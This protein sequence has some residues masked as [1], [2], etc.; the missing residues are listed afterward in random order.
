[1]AKITL[2]DLVNLQNETTAVNAINNNNAAIEVAMENTLSRDGT[3]PN[4]MGANLD[5]N[6]NR[7]LNLPSAASADEPV[8]LQDL[9][10]YA[11]GGV[12]TFN[13]VPVGGTTGQVLTKNSNTDYD[14]SWQ[15]IPTPPPSS[16]T[17]VNSQTGDVI[18]ATSPLGRLTLTS[19]TA[20]TTADVTG[21]T[22]IYYTFSQGN[23]IPIYSGT[24]MVPTTFTELTLALDSNGS[25]TN[26]HAANKNFDLFVFNNAGTIRL[27]TGPDWTAGAVAGSDTAR[28]TGLGSTELQLINGLFTNK[29][30]TLIRW[31]SGS[32]DT[33]TV[34]ANQATYVGTLRTTAN[35]Q[36][37]DSTVNRFVFN[38]Y[39]QS[40]RTF[41]R[42]ELTASWNYST[43][44]YRQANANAANKVQYVAGLTGG[45]I[46]L[47]VSSIP[48]NSTTTARI[49][50]TGVGV[51][52]TAVNS[53][54]T[55]DFARVGDATVPS[56]VSKAYFTGYASLGYH[57]MAW[58]EKGAGF[59]TQ[60]WFGTSA[61]YQAGMVGSI[62]A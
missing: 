18:I 37:E 19:G 8:R 4:Q 7:I 39:N 56:A 51:D 22:S 25:H 47:M 35:G 24:V 29:N 57:Y 31:G 9:A 15:T 40:K 3:S 45:M 30:A 23:Q 32:T 1:M 33:T 48:L 44:T 11:T 27:G 46:D 5:M 61:D 17:G 53:R 16:V 34:P 14:D 58:L 49:V 52:S 50:Y 21:A 20:V 43:A 28:G 62:F 12:V 13:A 41:V 26:Y 6:G 36:T 59:D 60:T 42:Q 2:T 55:G 10:D 38:A 54:T